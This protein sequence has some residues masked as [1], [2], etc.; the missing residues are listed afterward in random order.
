MRMTELEGAALA[1][2][3]NEQSMALQGWLFG[4]TAQTSFSAMTAVMSAYPFG[5][6]HAQ[7]GPKPA[8]LAGVTFWD[9]AS[10][11]PAPGP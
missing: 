8:C 9:A 1:A 2:L 6:P 5:L 3:D 4:C 11:D 7:R 10:T